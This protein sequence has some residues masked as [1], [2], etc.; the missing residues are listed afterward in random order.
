VVGSSW[1]FLLAV[2]VVAIWAATGP[3]FNYSE[4]WQLLINTGT[5]VVTFLMVFVIQN[6]QNGGVVINAWHR[7]RTGQSR[8]GARPLS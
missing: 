2:A 5:T 6:S 8:P 4:T 7:Q 3:M 1:S